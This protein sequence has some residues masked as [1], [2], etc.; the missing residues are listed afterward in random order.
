MMEVFGQAADSWTRN[1]NGVG[2]GLAIC[3]ELMRLHDGE[4]KIDSI[5]G[6]GTVVTLVFPA[7]NWCMDTPS[8]NNGINSIL[9]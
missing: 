2:L 9:I 7:K 8:D 6:M 1:H 3:D 4:L 5:K